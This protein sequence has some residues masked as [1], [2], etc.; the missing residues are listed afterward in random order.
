MPVGNLL[1]NVSIILGTHMDHKR[2]NN[3]NDIN[4]LAY[5]FPWGLH[6]VLTVEWL[7]S[8]YI[9]MGYRGT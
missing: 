6:E 8:L 2:S 5:G 7:N 9:S 1:F 4:G 3:L